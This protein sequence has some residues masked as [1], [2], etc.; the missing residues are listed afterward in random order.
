MALLIAPRSVRSG[1]RAWTSSTARPTSTTAWASTAR[2]T[3]T[4]RTAP[5]C[6]ALRNPERPV[7]RAQ[8]RIGGLGR[9]AGD[10]VVLAPRRHARPSGDDHVSWNRMLA[11]QAAAAATLR[12]VK[13]PIQA[14]VPQ[15]LP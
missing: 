10:A 7:L 15:D 2:A 11:G 8:Q 9:A 13:G 6:Y 4:S 12:E 3:P 1:A 14:L 5:R